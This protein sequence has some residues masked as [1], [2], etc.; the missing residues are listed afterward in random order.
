MREHSAS[1]CRRYNELGVECTPL[2]PETALA[3]LQRARTCA[4]TADDDALTIATLSKCGLCW[5]RRGCPGTAANNLRRASELDQVAHGGAPLA[6]SAL[7][8]PRDV[9]HRQRGPPSPCGGGRAAAAATGGAAAVSTCLTTAE[10][11]RLRLNL[12]TALCQLGQYEPALAEA[13]AAIRLVSAPFI[14]EE[15]DDVLLAVALHNR[16][17]CHEFLGNAR[18]ARAA[19]ERSL[20]L[21]RA[22]LP[23]DDKLLSRL[24]RIA[25]SLAAEQ[26]EAGTAT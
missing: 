5:L 11:A 22:N 17:V 4:A 16:C 14:D 2:S 9:T 12:C 7:P 26:A 10:R 25:V 13:N 20:E 21:A 6:R 3:L 24:A 19:A 15:K 1:L 23:A 8:S 18:A